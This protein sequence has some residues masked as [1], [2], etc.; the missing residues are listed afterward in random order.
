MKVVC[1]G[2]RLIVCFLIVVMN[3]VLIWYGKFILYWSDGVMFF[4][5]VRFGV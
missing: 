3:D 5:F 2:G 4:E 1:L